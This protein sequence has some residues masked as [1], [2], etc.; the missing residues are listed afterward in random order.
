MSLPKP[1]MRW[2]RYQENTGA[3]RYRYIWVLANNKWDAQREITIKIP[4]LN[5]PMYQLL[6]DK[7]CTI[8]NTY[9]PRVAIGKWRF[10]AVIAS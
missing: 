7:S 4:N 9:F 5:P 10:R 2:Y 3:V 8:P 6:V 1:T